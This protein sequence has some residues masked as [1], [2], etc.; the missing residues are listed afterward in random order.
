MIEKCLSHNRPTVAIEGSN[1]PLIEKHILLMF[2]YLQIVARLTFFNL[3]MCCNIQT[4]AFKVHFGQECQLVFF[5]ASI[6]ISSSIPSLQLLLDIP[7]RLLPAGV[8]FIICFSSRS[9]VVLCP[10][11][12]SCFVYNTFPNSRIRSQ[13]IFLSFNVA[14]L[15]CIFLSLMVSSKVPWLVVF[16]TRYCTFEDFLFFGRIPKLGLAGFLPHSGILFL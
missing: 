4:L 10:Y 11:N 15:R 14:F 1:C 2:L 8:Y 9:Y 3:S 12:F 7:L 16:T 6:L 13:R 5:Q